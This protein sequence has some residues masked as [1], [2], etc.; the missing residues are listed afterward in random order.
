[1]ERVDGNAVAGILDEVFAFETTEAR[2]R[3][4]ACGAV[5]QL[6]AAH[7]Y[8]HPLAPGAVVRCRACES[9]LVVA[10]R[11]DGRI[12]LACVGLTWLEIAES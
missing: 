10:V 4:D 3:C 1:M 11:A 5:W 6:G 9:V 7:V 2:G 8:A 12:R